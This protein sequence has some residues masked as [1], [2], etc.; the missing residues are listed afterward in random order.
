MTRED[1]LEAGEALGLSR[2]VAT[3]LLDVQVTRIEAEAQALLREVEAENEHTLHARPELAATFSGELRCL[4]AVV[5]LVIR[6][7]VAR[8][9]GHVGS[10]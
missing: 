5:A 1:L 6:D 2:E 9:G 8:L 4:R 3:R 7:M 10:Q